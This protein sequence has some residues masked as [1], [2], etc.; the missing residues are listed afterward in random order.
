M[1]KD[2][3]EVY[4]A[5]PHGVLDFMENVPNMQNA[6]GMRRDWAAIASFTAIAALMYLPFS[7]K[8]RLSSYLKPHSD[9]GIR[10]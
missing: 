8:N 9:R 5:Q 1:M 6:A 3:G 2:W 10:G 7:V 4:V